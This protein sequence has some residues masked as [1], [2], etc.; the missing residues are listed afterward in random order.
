[1]SERRSTKVPYGHLFQKK[2]TR[3]WYWTYYIK[4]QRRYAQIS[5]RCEDKADAAAWVRQKA[6]EMEHNGEGPEVLARGRSLRV[7]DFLRNWMVQCVHLSPTTQDQHK[8][9]IE[10]HIIP[11][12]GNRKL[13]DVT[14]PDLN[15]LY[16]ALLKKEKV[17]G[18][19]TLS[20]RT[21]AIC[22]AILHSAFKYAADTGKISSN[23]ADKAYRPKQVRHEIVPMTLEEMLAFL[24]AAKNSR[25][26]A[27][28]VLA[29]L[30]GLRLGELLA[31][32]W[33]DVDL[34][35]YII[36]VQH[37]LRRKGKS[38]EQR[39]DNTKTPTSVRTVPITETVV[40]VLKDHWL[41]Q[42]QERLAA[43]PAWEDHDLVF[44]NLRGRPTSDGH[45]RS[46]DFASILERA[47]LRHFRPHDMRHTMASLM[48]LAGEHPKIVQERLGHSRISMTV[49]TY[50]HL[51]PSLQREAANRLDDLVDHQRQKKSV[52]PWRKNGP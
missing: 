46:R 34:D 28:Y 37:S 23:P 3:F 38:V 4:G 33:R 52:K 12:I 43:G 45:L 25:Y 10:H 15:M 32:R 31:L 26:F 51:Q 7:G 1:M 27:L 19:G 9:L 17:D 41:Q 21:V 48:L 6:A 36:S 13:A 49:D 20:P 44:S 50:S 18:H 40:N 22:H 47:G 30:A 35:H 5:T 8:S 14:G 42:A 11:A 39:I 2:G 16:A 24:D 29:F